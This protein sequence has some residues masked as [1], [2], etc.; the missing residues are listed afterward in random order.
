M[1]PRPI[2][3]GIAGPFHWTGR[4]ISA[5]TRPVVATPVI[6]FR[7]VQMLGSVEKATDSWYGHYEGYGPLF[8][9]W[10]AA[11]FR[12][13]GK[14]LGAYRTSVREVVVG[15]REGDDEPIVGD[16]IGR[17]GMEAD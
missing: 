12:E 7:S 13:L 15:W 11:P 1:P 16:P 2:S 4:P 6:G 3:R 8:T 10:V 9:W 5:D 17:A 14:A